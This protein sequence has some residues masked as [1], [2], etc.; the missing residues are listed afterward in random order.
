MKYAFCSLLIV[1]LPLRHLSLT[2]PFGCRVHPLTG[3]YTLH[4]GVDLRA[5]LD[6]VYAV[7][8][9]RVE[10]VGNDPVLG[11]FIRITNGPFCI[12]YGHLAIAFVGNGD[13]LAVAQPIG[14]SGASGRVTGPHLHFAVQFHRRYIDPLEFLAAAFNK[15]L[16]NKRRSY[17]PDVQIAAGTGQRPDD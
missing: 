13:S 16:T 6:T 10:A 4:A 9:S 1:C 14:I 12:T 5:D 3:I 17:E 2:S 8:D 11:T 7:I 15:F